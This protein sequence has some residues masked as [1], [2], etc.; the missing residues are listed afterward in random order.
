MVFRIFSGSRRP[1]GNR[2]AVSA[3]GQRFVISEFVKSAEIE[4]PEITV[5][6]NW[7]AGL[8]R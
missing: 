5:M 7:P 8:K 3:D 4:R 2:F 6:L 1:S